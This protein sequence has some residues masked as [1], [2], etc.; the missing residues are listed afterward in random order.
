MI[1]FLELSPNEESVLQEVLSN[2]YEN[3]TP[4]YEY[5]ANRFTDLNYANENLLRST[6]GSLCDKGYISI[7]F[8]PDN[9]PEIVIL[10]KGKEYFSEKKRFLKEK[11]KEEL[12]I[13]KRDI[14]VAVCTV[15]L[16]LLAEHI[17]DIVT[18]IGSLF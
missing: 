1:D 14:L 13:T 17:K 18:F 16:T 3:G 4:S 6:L 12:N 10:N 15:L 11:K 5:W 2:T 7:P 8:W 9:N